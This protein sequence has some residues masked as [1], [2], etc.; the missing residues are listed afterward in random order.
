MARYELKRHEVALLKLIRLHLGTD[1]MA[2]AGDGA[3][4]LSEVE[5]QDTFLL[6]CSQGVQAVT[7]EAVKALPKHLLPPRLTLLKWAFGSAMIK[8]ENGRKRQVLA[9]LCRICHDHGFDPVLLKGFTIAQY[10]PQ[11]D[12]RESGDFDVWFPDREKES[13]AFFASQT[14]DIHYDVKHT[15]FTFQEVQVENHQSLLCPAGLLGKRNEPIEARL[16]SYWREEPSRRLD[17]PQ[18]EHILMPSPAFTLLFAARHQMAHFAN[19][20]SLRL[21]VDW[22]LLLEGHPSMDIAAILADLQ[23]PSYIAANRLLALTAQDALGLGKGTFSNYTAKERQQ[24]QRLLT[25]L[26]RPVSAEGCRRGTLRFWR[27]I[28]RIH[29]RSSWFH[30]V[31]HGEGRLHYMGRVILAKLKSRL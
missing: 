27:Q 13:D 22:G 30:K 16:R 12:L 31:G 6:A 23:R 17:L 26:V 1:D 25:Y 15:T 9:D 4:N 3:L 2:S 24:A 28:T 7:Y 21:L 14:D 10:Y 8:N 5:W 29:W 18:D 11:P 19:N 20:F